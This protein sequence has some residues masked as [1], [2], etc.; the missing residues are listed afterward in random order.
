MNGKRELTAIEAGMA[1]TIARLEREKAELVEAL[2][3]FAQ[4]D[5]SIANSGNIQGDDSP[6][7]GKDGAMLKLGDFRRARRLY[8]KHGS[9]Q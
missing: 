8:Q 3:P 5:L 9:N 6:V 4:D 7:W 2:K 1:E